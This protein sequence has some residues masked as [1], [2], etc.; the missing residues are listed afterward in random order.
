M[1]GKI[2][3]KAGEEIFIQNIIK[4]ALVIDSLPKYVILRLAIN[5]TFRLEYKRLDN[6]SYANT[7]P[8]D[9]SAKGG[10]YNM[11][12]VTGDGKNK[13]YT[14]LLRLAFICR[15][16]EEGLDFSDDSVFTSTV[17]KYIHRGL[18]EL[19]N[20]YKTKDDFY[21]FLLDEFKETSFV[22]QNTFT[23][24]Q[25]ISKDINE[26]NFIQYIK[27]N[28]IK[29][30]ILTHIDALRHDVIKL[31]CDDMKTYEN[32]K[33]EAGDYKIKFGLIGDANAVYAGEQMCLNVYFPKPE[34]K[35]K[36]FGLDEFLK[37]IKEYNRKFW[38]GVY[39][40]RDILSKP[41]FLDIS[42]HL[43]VAGTS[44][45]GKS[46]LL[47]TIITSLGLINKN[48]EFILIDPKNGAEFGI[49]DNSKNLSPLCNNK[50]IKDINEVKNITQI[51]IDEMQYRYDFFAKQGVSKNSELKEPLSKIVIVFDEVADAFLQI[52]ELQDDIVRIAQK[53]RAA[54]IHLVIATQTP[55]ANILKQEL[56]ANIDTRIALK[57][58]NSKGSTIII[59]ETGAENLLGKGDMLVKIG[60]DINRIFSPYLDSS[61]I[62]TILS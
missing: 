25:S 21:Q 22:N 33:K 10:E 5:K 27:Q 20:I 50:V 32:I 44:G 7:I 15:H 13:D 28:N 53:A 30:Q 45:S 16:K 37:D 48:I 47:H 59:D 43:L 51:I 31:K 54:D 35:W 11:E 4:N 8:Y 34:S 18:F 55:N 62:K 40:G 39:C 58:Q 60:S 42:Q 56:R 24:S 57:T 19:N 36:N 38:L 52:K 49:Y 23:A 41:F 12:Q 2:Y 3:T 9:G 17:D 1:L 26:I 14:D 46:V 6:P 29:A 61:D